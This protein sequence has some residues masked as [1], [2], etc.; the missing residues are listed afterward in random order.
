LA[1]I[2]RM[3]AA[4]GADQTTEAAPVRN[5]HAGAAAAGIAEKPP[6]AEKP[7]SKDSLD[8]TAELFRSIFKGEIVP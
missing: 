6:V 7:V 5:P 4:P 2:D 8:E 1:V 3:M